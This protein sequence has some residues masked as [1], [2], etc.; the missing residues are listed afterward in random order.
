MNKK[1][2]IFI[3]I[4]FQESLVTKTTETLALR[5]ILDYQIPVRQNGF[6]QRTFS[7]LHQVYQLK[8]YQYPQV[9]DLVLKDERIQRAVE[10]MTVQQFQDAERSDDEFYK[11]LLSSNKKR[12]KKLMY[13]MRSKLSDFLLR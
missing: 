5:N 11:Q 6:L 8:K 12:A 7:H 9:A 3:N 1:P 2:K 10:K 13:D 4:F